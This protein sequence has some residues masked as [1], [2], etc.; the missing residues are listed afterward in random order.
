MSGR[1]AFIYSPEYTGYR[2][3]ETHPLD[4]IR[5][6]LT[7]SLI[8]DAGLL[9]GP[10]VVAVAPRMGT[11]EELLL[12]H[13]LEYVDRVRE[14]SESGRTAHPL[15]DFGLGPGDTPSFAG[16]HEATSLVVGGSVLGADLVLNGGATH[17]FN[18]GGGLHHAMRRLASG[19]CIYNDA[20]IAVAWLRRHGARVLY[21]DT[22]A[23]HGDGVQAAFYDD[24]GVLTIS[25][26]ESGRFLFPGTGGVEE[27][28]VGAG[29]GYAV[30]VPVQPYTHHASFVE[31]YDIVVPTL[32]RQ[33]KPD[34]IV[35]QSGCDSY[36][37][38][39]LTHLHASTRT[40]E[41]Y[42]RQAHDLAHELCEGRLLVLGGGGYALWT[43]VPRAWTAVWA[44]VSHQ[45]LPFD[46]PSAWRAR[47]QTEAR[48]SLPLLM[49]DV[50]DELVVLPRQEEITAVN[51]RIAQ[52]VASRGL[53]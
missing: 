20:S 2:L 47:W 15:M 48:A 45:A 51:R 5:L 11:E 32:A 30:N 21:I 42:A 49:H 10:D 53:G 52:S 28:G 9:V 37:E 23:H 36:V 24:P 35:A 33:F 19:F 13:D 26:H 29:F 3:S 43:G 38:D 39:P 44:A 40:F 1:S 17:A 12:A 16:M 22:D 25:I 27:R 6:K 8:E 18:P 41:H 50:D 14:V 4:P 31:C 34:V 7:A 46:V